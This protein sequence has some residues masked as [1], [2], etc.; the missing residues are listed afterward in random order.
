MEERQ[1]STEVCRDVEI[2]VFHLDSLD[3]RVETLI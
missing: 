3:I 1:N 2:E